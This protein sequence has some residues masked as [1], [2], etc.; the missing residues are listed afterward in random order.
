MEVHKKSLGKVVMTPE[1]A[2]DQTREYE[3]LSLVYHDTTTRA[4]VSKQDV[5]V[6]IDIHNKEYWMPFNVSGYAESNIIAL[7]PRRED[8]QIFGISLVEAIESIAE[9]GRKPGVILCFYNDNADRNDAIARWEIWQ[10]DSINIYDWDNLSC[11]TNLYYSYNKFVGWFVSEEALLVNYPN[12]S[13]GAYA[14]VGQDKPSTFIYRCEEEGVWVNTEMYAYSDGSAL[15]QQP[16]QNA[17]IAMSQKAVTDY[18]KTLED[19][20]ADLNEQ[21]NPFSVSKFNGGGTFEM[22]SSQTINLSWDY[23]R[24]IAAQTLNGETLDVTVKS[25]KFEGVNVNTNYTLQATSSAGKSTSKTVSAKF[26]L[27]KYWGV[28]DKETLSNAEILALSKD[29]AKREQAPT[30]FDCTGGKYAFYII[31]ASMTPGIQFWIG[32]LRVTDWVEIS[33]E[34]NNVH[35]YK[36]VYSVYRLANKQN[37]QI[38]IEVK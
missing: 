23:N 21:V 37:G 34:V 11:W 14:H 28:S 38:I 7:E 31:P 19:K 32:G 13:I 15:A 30:E 12:P 5:P 4:F 22:G 36:E 16:G 29:W 18:V 17:D 20:I 8:G 27:K 9:V 2:W 24:E 1:G 3:I 33:Q 35:N 25:A 26:A 10:F 6:G